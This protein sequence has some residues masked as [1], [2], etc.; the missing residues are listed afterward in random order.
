MIVMNVF[1]EPDAQL[2]WCISNIRKHYKAA[3]VKVFFQGDAI[4]NQF[5]SKHRV[6]H[7]QTERLYLL[8]HGGKVVEVF[9]TE[10]VETNCRY[11]LKVDPDTMF[12]RRISK[13]PTSACLFG[14]VQVS[15]KTQRLFSIQGGCIGINRI[16]AKSI[17][18]SGVLRREDF[19]SNKPPWSCASVVQRRVDN[20]LVS[21]DWM[22]GFAI[23]ECGIPMA[24]H[25]EISSEWRKPVSDCSD[26]A[27]SHPHKIV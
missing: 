3:K 22:M 9:L 25:P 17:L 8:K 6:E 4:A 21:I 7:C 15:D 20:G 27:V 19:S 14:T 2:Q 18:E 5:L 23:A 12:N 10:F 1:D 13:L 16:A 24:R 11:L 26:F